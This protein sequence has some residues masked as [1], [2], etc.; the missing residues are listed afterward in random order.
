MELDEFKLSWNKHLEDELKGKTITKPLAKM[1]MKLSDTLNKLNDNSLFWWRLT[2]NAIT[3]L[4]MM[5][6]IVICCFIFLPEKFQN[7]KN[8][9][10]VFGV[11]ALYGLGLLWVYYEKAKIFDI[12]DSNNIR[13]AVEKAISRF[14]R[15]YVFSNLV[16]VFLLPLPF[17]LMVYILSKT[18]FSKTFDLNTE[19]LICTVLTIVTL[20]G[21]HMYYKLT[22]FKWLSKLRG[23]LKELD[24][25]QIDDAG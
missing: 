20:V 10:P 18:F 19:V 8:A 16:Y 6:V 14:N 4:F 5:L 23:S 17:Y 11:I 12:S 21:N 15:W 13:N 24:E 3:L 25:H 7:I 22:Y 9:L 1:S 2:K